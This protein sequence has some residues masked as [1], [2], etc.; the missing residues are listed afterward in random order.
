MFNSTNK[1][2]LKVEV[3]HKNLFNYNWEILT[4]YN[5]KALKRKQERK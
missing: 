5:S 3:I 4:Y 2:F 1:T